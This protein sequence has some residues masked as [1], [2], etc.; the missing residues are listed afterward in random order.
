[1]AVVC[2]CFSFRE[3]CSLLDFRMI[4]VVERIPIVDDLIILANFFMAIISI[5]SRIHRVVDAEAFP[6]GH[7]SVK[8]CCT[9]KNKQTHIDN[10]VCILKSDSHFRLV[11]LQR[12]FI[13]VESMSTAFVPLETDPFA[14]RFVKVLSLACWHRLVENCGCCVCMF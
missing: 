2:A 6:R 1:M 14:R 11:G 5:I 9:K 3:V 7:S 13:Y 8:E 4:D 12:N 10:N